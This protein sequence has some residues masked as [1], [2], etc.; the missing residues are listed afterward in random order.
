MVLRGGTFGGISI[1]GGH[2]GRLLQNR[3]SAFLSV[4]ASLFSAMWVIGA[5]SCPTLCN[6]V[7]CSLPASSVHFILQARILAWLPFPFPF[8]HVRI[9]T[10]WQPPTLGNGFL[11]DTGSA[12]TLILDFPASRTVKNECIL[13]K[14][15]NPWSF[16][17]AARA[18]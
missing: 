15:L 3:I 11:P 12:R 18:D 6:P 8:C 13:L 4:I 9:T 1:R 14:S 2:T 10:K 7:D 16:V 17:R 5:Q